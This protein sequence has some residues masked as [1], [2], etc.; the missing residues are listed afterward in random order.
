MSMRAAA[1]LSAGLILSA[2]GGADD[3]A[4]TRAPAP[5]QLEYLSVAPEPVPDEVYFDATLEAVYQST[6]AAQTSARVEEMPFDVGDYV[7][8]G[9]VIV[10]FRATEQ[11][12]RAASAQAGVREAEARLA[13]A[14]SEFERVKDLHARGVLARAALDRATAALKSTQAQVES[15]RAAGRG[16]AEQLEYTVVRAPYAGI[17]VARHIEV[18]ETAT[19]GKPL[20]T[21]L[22]LEHLRAVVD[23][24]QTAI[25]AVHA[26]KKA[27]VILPDGSGVE[28]ARLRIPPSADA[29]TH[30]FRVL[31][32]LPE[33]QHG[34]PHTL[35]PG[36]LV[37]VGFVR[38]ERM[39]MLLPP[40]AVVQRS[41]L[42]AVYVLDDRN[43]PVLRYVRLGSP[44][45]DGRVPVL[46]GL[47][48]N[49]RI[50]LDPVAAAQLLKSGSGA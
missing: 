8:K 45:A 33:G 5:V 40:Q 15:A 28:T 49:E 14:Q 25:A 44:T 31:A 50:A 41:E 32:T 19:V 3:A 2:C 24:P 9:Q 6:V 39:A 42:T 12:A 22:S 20:M 34:T 37:K 16:A 13:D 7:E 48:E 29:Q 36:T 21:G 23:V 27:R 18:G 47:T 35:F 46:A 30:T 38:D 4:V 10:R 11:Q 1:L 43:W 26:R 17:V